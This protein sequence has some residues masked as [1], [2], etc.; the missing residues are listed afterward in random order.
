MS[1]PATKQAQLLQQI[2]MAQMEQQD[3]HFS[4]EPSGK[5]MLRAHWHIRY[6]DDATMPLAAS[7]SLHHCPILITGIHWN[8]CR[9]PHSL[10]SHSDFRHELHCLSSCSM[11]HDVL[12]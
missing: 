11:T 12:I 2:S 8:A 3:Y 6:L 7:Q 1:R 5:M 4:C 9:S 10:A